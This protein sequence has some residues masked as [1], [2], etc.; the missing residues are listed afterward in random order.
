VTG[1]ERYSVETLLKVRARMEEGIDRAVASYEDGT[2][3]V[4]PKLGSATPK[5]AAETIQMLL[6]GIDKEL[7]RR[8]EQDAGQ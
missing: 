3:L 5:E 8:P 1:F 2:F 4:R 6:D 7:K